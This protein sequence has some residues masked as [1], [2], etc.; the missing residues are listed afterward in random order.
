MAPYKL[1][2]D[3]TDHEPPIAVHGS[4]SMNLAEA[5]HRMVEVIRVW[6]LVPVAQQDSSPNSL[7]NFCRVEDRLPGTVSD[8]EPRCSLVDFPYDSG[9]S[10]AD[11]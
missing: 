3:L 4:Q 5:E 1:A 10:V 2:A 7:Q 6:P 8:I 9:V 11:P